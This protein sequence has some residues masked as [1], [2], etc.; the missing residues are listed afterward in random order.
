[1][2]RTNDPSVPPSDVAC[3]P[4]AARAVFIVAVGV[5][6]IQIVRAWRLGV[7]DHAVTVAVAWTVALPLAW[8]DA[9]ARYSPG[10][11]PDPPDRV[12]RVLGALAAV[13]A[14]AAALLAHDYHMTDRVL[15]LIAGAALVLAAWGKRGLAHH[16]RELLV[17]ALPLINPMPTALRTALAPTHWTAWSAMMLN[18]SVGHE[19]TVAGNVLSMPGATL[20]VAPYCGGIMSMSELWVLGIIV[21]ALFPMTLRQRFALLASATILG[22]FVN[23]VRIAVLASAI[24]RGDAAYEYWHQGAGSGLFSLG[25]TALAGVVWWWMLRSPSRPAALAQPKPATGCGT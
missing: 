23:A 12:A 24:P 22:F 25:A 13:V 6:A 3:V 9:F 16:R 21:M 5:A 18:R 19:A 14:L 2:V 8:K 17:L 11:P 1:V 10:S 15:P 20:E 4:A 7:P